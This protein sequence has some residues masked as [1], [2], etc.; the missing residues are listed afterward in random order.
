MHQRIEVTD[1]DILCTLI[2]NL[3]LS[4]ILCELLPH[5]TPSAR[6]SINIFKSL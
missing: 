4:L 5:L 2:T 6:A 1:H 3:F